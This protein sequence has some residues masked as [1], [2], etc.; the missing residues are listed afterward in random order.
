MLVVGAELGLLFGAACHYAV[1]DLNMPL[2]AFAVVGMAAFFTAVVRGADHRDRPDHRNDGQLHDAVADARHLLHGHAR[3]DFAWQSANLR[4]AARETVGPVNGTAENATIA[5]SHFFSASAKLASATAISG[6]I[7]IVR[8]LRR[9]SET[10]LSTEVARPVC[11]NHAA[12]TAA[13]RE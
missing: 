4:I 11:N 10:A 5:Y 6:R 13:L 8:A 3:A 2:E 1:P 12:T 9:K 7:T